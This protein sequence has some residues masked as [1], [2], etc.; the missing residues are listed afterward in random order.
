MVVLDTIIFF[1]TNGL[2]YIYL[3]NQFKAPRTTQNAG[4]GYTIFMYNIY[5]TLAFLV[6]LAYSVGYIVKNEKAD[7]IALVLLKILVL[8]W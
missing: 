4:V 1:G 5:I 3:M 8:V 2:G 7:K 6:V